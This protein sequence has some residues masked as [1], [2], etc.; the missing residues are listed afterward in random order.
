MR[1]AK[2]NFTNKDF[3][4]SSINYMKNLSGKYFLSLYLDK[5][6]LKN[7]IKKSRIP[8]RF[9]G[10]TLPQSTLKSVDEGCF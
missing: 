10:G 8:R 4:I 5:E 1:F 7:I 2:L 3:D 9:Q 6:K